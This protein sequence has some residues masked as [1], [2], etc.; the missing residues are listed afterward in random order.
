MEIFGIDFLKSG[1]KIKIKEKNKGKFTTAAKTAGH[2]V[3]EYAKVV[4]NDPNAT[5]LQKKR[6]NFAR[7]AKK[8]KHQEGGIFI[9]IKKVMKDPVYKKEF[10]W[11]INP[12]NINII[13][14]SIQ[15]RN[16]TKPQTISILSQVIPEN[17]GNTTSHGNG[18]YGLVG[19]RGTRAIGLS[20]KLSEQIHKLMVETLENP[21][22]K[23]WSHGGKGT[24]IKTG[25]EMNQFWKSGA[26]NNVRKATNA[27]MRGYVRPPKEVYDK[28]LKFAEYLKS[29]YGN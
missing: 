29:Q 16:L 19:W 14:D 22:G 24:G 5:S 18:A 1:N 15:A 23:D 25:K 20:N 10:G 2:S 9:D 17:G 7:N 26:Y 4:L 11:K 6:A 27:F 3:Q 13:Q 12:D 8:W 21:K 28:R